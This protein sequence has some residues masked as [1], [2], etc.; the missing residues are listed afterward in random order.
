MNTLRERICAGLAALR[1]VRD[2]YARSTRYIVYRDEYRPGHNFYVGKG[3][4]RA[5]TARPSLERNPVQ[6]C[7]D[8]DIGCGQPS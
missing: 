8:A 3:G 2:P 1:Y 4:V 5:G 7:S 6:L